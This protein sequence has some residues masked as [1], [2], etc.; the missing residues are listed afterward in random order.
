MH[1]PIPQI[2]LLN[3]TLSRPGI[4]VPGALTD[5]APVLLV[6]DVEVSPVCAGIGVRP[7]GQ[8]GGG[9]GAA[10]HG[11]DDAVGTA[12]D[13]GA[14][15]ADARGAGCQGGEGFEVRVWLLVDEE[16]LGVGEGGVLEDAHWGGGDAWLGL[17]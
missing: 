9:E 10:A 13:D 14:P 3:Q 1:T 2:P 4:F 7:D 12:V 5:V 8:G 11:I 17:C 6:E 15:G 16:A